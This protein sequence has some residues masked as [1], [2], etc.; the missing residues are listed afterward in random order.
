MLTNTTVVYSLIYLWYYDVIS[1]V[2]TI[3]DHRRRKSLRTA[4][5]ALVVNVSVAGLLAALLCAPLI[6][7]ANYRWD[8]KVMR[9]M[10]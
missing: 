4:V 6:Y 3:D 8:N 5:N 10:I 1:T 2:T 9:D 7:V